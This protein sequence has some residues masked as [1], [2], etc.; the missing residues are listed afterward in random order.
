MTPRKLLRLLFRCLAVVVV[1]L[2]PAASSQASP[3]SFEFGGVLTHADPST[4]AATGT[5]FTGAVGY[6]PA[7][8]TVTVNPS[9]QTFDFGP[10][11]SL[12]IK[13]GDS[14]VYSSQG[15]LHMLRS[16]S[17]TDIDISGPQDAAGLNPFITLRHV[18]V[19][20]RSSLLPPSN[21][22][23]D[24]DGSQTTFVLH[25]NPGDVPLYSGVINTLNTVPEP[26]TLAA[27]VALLGG[28][29]LR[30]SWKRRRFARSLGGSEAG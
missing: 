22:Q 19:V 25:R 13:I 27:F 30:A 6:D 11:S 15:N 28:S 23:L 1:L 20:N 21:I 8:S 5:P 7:D 29:A 16:V 9:F 10:S 18:A 4:G 2:S 26:S 14:T 12:T 3:L 24:P 17:G